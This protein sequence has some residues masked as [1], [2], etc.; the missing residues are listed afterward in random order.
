MKKFTFG[1]DV[2]GTLVD[3]LDMSQHLQAMV[4]DKATELSRLWREKQVEY[5]FRRGL[6]ERYENFGVCTQQALHFA[7]DSLGVMLSE[8]QQQFLMAQ[9]QQLKAYEDVLPG[10][11]SL[12]AQGHQCVA[13]SNGPA[14]KVKTLLENAAV[15][16]HLSDVVSVDEIKT[17]KPNPIV[18]HHLVSRTA[19][20][21]ENT[22]L[23]SSNAWDVM[24]AKNAGLKA[25][26][27][28]RSSSSIFDPWGITPDMIVQN[29]QQLADGISVYQG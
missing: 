12:N 23:I 29:L 11:E 3:P 22:W 9:Y 4:G 2:Y 19:S 1:F 26:W 17:F 20:T 21:A 14:E 13:F 27:V 25:A 28:Q 10:I 5:A 15:L 8:E 18:Y 16:E 7:M 24:G 6:M